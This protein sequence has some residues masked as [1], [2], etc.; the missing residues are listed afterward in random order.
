MKSQFS[1]LW[2]IVSLVFIIQLFVISSIFLIFDSF[3]DRGAFGDMFGATNSIFSGLAFAGVVYTLL[4]QS[5]QITIQK[6]ELE[7]TRKEHS[8]SAVAQENS[9]DALVKTMIADHD[10]RKKHATVE[11]LKSVRPIWSSLRRELNDHFGTG[12]LTESNLLEI[13]KDKELQRLIRELLGGMEH[14]AV[15]ANCDVFDRDLIYRMSASSFIR[16]CKRMDLYIERAQQKNPYSYIEFREL[17][18]EFEEQRRMRPDPRGTI[19]AY[20]PNP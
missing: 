9:H 5:R 7:M 15:G 10:R 3:P 12:P 11:Y 2:I 16:I 1:S 14:L 17:V 8:R 6:E 13:D 4:L 20:I 18:H 19:A